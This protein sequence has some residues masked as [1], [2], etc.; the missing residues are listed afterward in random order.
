MFEE[1]H[2]L[3]RSPPV[4]E[5]EIIDGG[6][7]TRARQVALNVIDE[8]IANREFQTLN[9]VTL[10]PDHLGPG[11]LSHPRT[12]SHRPCLPHR[13]SLLITKSTK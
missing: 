2:E 8:A 3:P 12:W 1:R 5:Q 4:T 9:F 6:T 7:G 13:L 11:E 10:P